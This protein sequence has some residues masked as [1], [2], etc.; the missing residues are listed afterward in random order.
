MRNPILHM[1][2]I[3]N[4][5]QLIVVI[6]SVIV[7]VYDHL[8]HP[9]VSPENVLLSNRRGLE[10]IDLSISRFAPLRFSASSSNATSITS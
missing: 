2:I 10:S 9:V 6:I 5:L 8:R 1:Y 3:I 4:N 7:F